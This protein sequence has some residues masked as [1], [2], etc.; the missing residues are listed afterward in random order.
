M[1][2]AIRASVVVVG[3][4][5][6]LASPAFPDEV[7]AAWTVVQEERPLAALLAVR[8]TRWRATRPPGGAYD[9]IELHR[10]R[11]QGPPVP[12]PA[13]PA[14]HEHEREPPHRPRTTNVARS[15][16]RAAWT[17]S[18]ST[19][20]ALSFPRPGSTTSAFMK[21]WSLRRSMGDARAA[22]GR[23][24]AS[25]ARA[26]LRV[27]V[28]PRRP[29]AYALA[30]A[31]PATPSP[32]RRP[33][34]A[35][36]RATPPRT[37]RSAGRPEEKLETSGASPA[38]SRQPRLGVAAAPDAG[39]LGEADGPTID[40]NTRR[41]PTS[42]PTP[43]H[44]LA[45]G[46]LATAKEGNVDAGGPGPTARGLRPILPAVQDVDGRAIAD[47]ADDPCHH[48]RRRWGR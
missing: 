24:R 12:V 26:A 47:L 27:G 23:H 48:R 43:L 5:A 19:T 37:G 25:R 22:A 34:T 13:L 42:W 36:S 16:P 39:R 28:Q 3:T 18:R 29:L 21:D 44:G 30:L 10:Y 14:G 11:G 17:S 32:D 8:E 15:P 46:G 4:L 38:M 40:A 6:S 20:D 7:G 31:E 33:S 41:P 9:Q 35:P 45:A 1:R 2:A